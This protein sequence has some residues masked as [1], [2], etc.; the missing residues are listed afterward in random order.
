MK[1]LLGKTKR[2]GD[3]LVQE[4]HDTTR[5]THPKTADVVALKDK[6]LVVPVSPAN[7]VK[8]CDTLDE[9]LGF[10]ERYIGLNE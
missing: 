8:E 6:Y 4:V 2:R 3:T 5:V 10:I 7:P 9:A 1:A